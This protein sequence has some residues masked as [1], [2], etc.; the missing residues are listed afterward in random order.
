[1]KIENRNNLTL[2][3]LFDHLKNRYPNAEIKKPFRSQ[4]CIVIPVKNMKHV[5]RTKG[6][7]FNTDFTIPIWLAIVALFGSVLLF[8]GVISLIDGQFKFSIG[9][10]LWMLLVLLAAKAI[11]RLVKKEEF[12]AFYAAVSIAAR[13]A[14]SDSSIF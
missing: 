11:Y 7:D 2:D 10:A 13:A 5:I 6:A 12:N 1:M 14:K 4:R 9:G 8:S 3:E